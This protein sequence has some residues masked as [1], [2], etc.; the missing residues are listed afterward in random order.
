MNQIKVQD[1][2]TVANYLQSFHHNW[3]VKSNTGNTSSVPERFPIDH[4]FIS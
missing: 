4:I 2:K 3:L 1:N